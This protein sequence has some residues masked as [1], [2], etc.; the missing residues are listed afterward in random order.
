MARLPMLQLP[1]P[2]DAR[3]QVEVYRTRDRRMTG[4]ALINRRKRLWVASPT[5]AM[6]G[7][8]TAYPHGFEMDHV[9]PLHAGGSDTDDNCQVLCIG[10][11]RTKTA[12]DAVQYG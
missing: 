8:L 12:R 6:C 5:C 10:C 11:H 2:T 7:L 9:V 3:K 4:H 1:V